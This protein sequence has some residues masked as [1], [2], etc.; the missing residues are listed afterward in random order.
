MP[1]TDPLRARL[2]GYGVPYRARFGTDGE[3]LP[4]KTNPAREATDLANELALLIGTDG[5]SSQSE[6][7]AWALSMPF[8][9]CGVDGRPHEYLTIYNI[10]EGFLDVLTDK[11][12]KARD[13]TAGEP[14]PIVPG[15]VIRLRARPSAGRRVLVGFQTEDRTPLQGN[16]APFTLDGIVPDAYDARLIKAHAAFHQLQTMSTEDPTNYRD[17]LEEFFSTMATAI[18]GNPEITQIQDEARRQGAYS[19]EDEKALNARQQ[20]LLKSEVLERIRNQDEALFRFPG[21]FGGITTL[22]NLVG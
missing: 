6:D 15:M 20:A 3:V 16:A 12:Y 5:S 18:A 9:R 17:T 2:F 14:Q 7:G 4:L 8:G 13:I 22:F 10:E 19:V 11:G 1:A 21:M